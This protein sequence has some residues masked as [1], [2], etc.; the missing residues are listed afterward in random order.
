L[1]H[2]FLTTQ[3]PFCFINVIPEKVLRTF[4]ETICKMNKIIR[5]L[6]ALGLR[7]FKN[8]EL[9]DYT[10]KRITDL[11]KNIDSFPGLKPTPLDLNDLNQEYKRA[12]SS[13]VRNSVLK[14]T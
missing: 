12:L 8:A 11:L 2:L 1:Q 10:E 6:P 4:S 13:R 9:I 14:K 7:G 5:I 3:Y